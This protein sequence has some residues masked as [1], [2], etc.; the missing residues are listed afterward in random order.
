MWVCLCAGPK[1][2][3][4]LH[5][6]QQ[7]FAGATCTCPIP[8]KQS[9]LFHNICVLFDDA[10]PL[11]ELRK[12]HVVRLQGSTAVGPSNIDQLLQQQLSPLLD[13]LLSVQFFTGQ[14]AAEAK[15]A[16]NAAR[17]TKAALHLWHG[18]VHY[19]G[20][21]SQEGPLVQ[22]R[23]AHQHDPNKKDGPIPVLWEDTLTLIAKA[24]PHQVR[25]FVSRE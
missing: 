14:Q 5:Y 19:A 16:L 25:R 9:C 8:S 24:G 11:T 1:T 22:T 13:G 23:V 20:H 6:L 21:G 18:E 12:V 4:V 7:H 2:N 15:T 10:D 3:P 17:S